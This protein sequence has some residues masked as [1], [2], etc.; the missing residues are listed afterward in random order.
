MDGFARG[1]SPNPFYNARIRRLRL[2]GVDALRYTPGATM[3]AD[4]YSRF[5]R[6]S[7][8]QEDRLAAQAISAEFIGHC[9][10]RSYRIVG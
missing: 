9:V 4:E 7:L 5:A 6:D 1:W 10:G 3:L 8:S 2:A